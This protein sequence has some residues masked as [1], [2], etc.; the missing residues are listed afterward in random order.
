M[1]WQELRISVGMPELGYARIFR[2]QAIAFIHLFPSTEW[3]A[4]VAFSAQIN[5]SADRCLPNV[6]S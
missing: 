5:N 6:S 3:A 2:L 4:T 1:R